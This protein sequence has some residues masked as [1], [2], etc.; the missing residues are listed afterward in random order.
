MTNLNHKTCWINTTLNE[1]KKIPIKI[2]W[3]HY[4]VYICQ[5]Y[6]WPINTY[7]HTYMIENNKCIKSV[8][9]SFVFIPPS[10]AWHLVTF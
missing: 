2:Y 6:I 9:L 3:N 4:E 5:G 8:F 1:N 7:I 10:G